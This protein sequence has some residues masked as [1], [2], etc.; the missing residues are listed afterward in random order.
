[1]VVAGTKV[2]Y[3]TAGAGGMFCGSCMHDNALAKALMQLGLDVM[4][5]PTYT[6]IRTDEDDVSVD[7]VFFGGINV[8]LQQ[9]FPPLRWLPGF[10]DRFLDNPKLIRRMTSRSI[11]MPPEELGRLAI[12]MLKGTSGNQRK[13]VRRLANW[14][15]NESK[16]DVV[17]FTNIL[18]GG[19]IPEIKRI[20]Q[21]PILV[22]LQGDDVFLD[23]LPKKFRSQCIDQIKVLAQQVDGFIVHSEF[24]RDYMSE[25]FSIP[26]EKIHVTPLGI[27][28]A[29]FESL[30]PPIRSGNVLGYLARLAPE[31]GFHNLVRAFIELKQQNGIPDLQLKVAGWLSK[32]NEPYAQQE[33]DRIRS[34]GFGDKFHYLG[35]LDRKQKL[36]FLNSVDV[37]SVPTDFLEPKGLYILEALAAGVPVVQP[38]HGCFP[39]L[40]GQCGGG[41]LFDPNN[42]DDLIQK[43]HDIFSNQDYRA[44]L[45]ADGKANVFKAR[46]IEF[47]AAH[48]AKLIQEYV[49]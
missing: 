5:V 7:Q 29:E 31:K 8:Y 6:P 25:Y 14:L 17:L 12:S 26:Q 40:V 11:D 21:K 41:I 22:T 49:L 15:G 27:E 32:Q 20:T 47:A 28:M 35:S 34:A 24:Y 9:K 18:I 39:E 23:S 45:S 10:L 37:L 38:N 4:L 42:A 13:E 2:V 43:L 19:C 36:D 30:G 48:T 1:M 16:P 33:F 44:Q 46:S 3:L